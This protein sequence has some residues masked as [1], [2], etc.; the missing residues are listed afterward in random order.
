M[1]KKTSQPDNNVWF[2]IAYI[3]PLITGILVLL[4]NGDKNKRLKLHA[5]QAIFLGIAIIVV[6]IIFGLLA[7]V[8]F[9][10]LGVL[11]TLIELILWLY[12]IYVG[13]EAYNGKDVPIPTIT[14]YAK[15]YS[16]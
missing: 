15:R 1:A 16:G 2:I 4:I 11:G 5:I 10:L 9:G 14:D 13:F 6:S 7:L 12:G 3:I 8:S